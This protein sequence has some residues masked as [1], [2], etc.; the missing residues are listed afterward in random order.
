[1][2]QWVCGHH[3]KVLSPIYSDK[4]LKSLEMAYS[5]VSKDHLTFTE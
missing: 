1:M 2:V 3:F 4:L 5:C